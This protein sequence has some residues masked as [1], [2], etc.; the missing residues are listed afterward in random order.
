MDHS[1][2]SNLAAGDV[3]AAAYLTINIGTAETSRRELDEQH[4]TDEC[5]SSSIA[6]PLMSWRP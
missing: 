6:S 3:I 1:A 4:L 2:A 5:A